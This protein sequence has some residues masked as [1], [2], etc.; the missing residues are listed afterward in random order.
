[1]QGTILDTE[2]SALKKK[3]DKPLMK[4]PFQWWRLVNTQILH[5]TKAEHNE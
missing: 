4:L 3:K 1:M 2:D 5:V